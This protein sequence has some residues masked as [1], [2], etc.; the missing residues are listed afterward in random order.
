M[1]FIILFQVHTST[2][3]SAQGWISSTMI[4]LKHIPS[5]TLS[6]INED[7]ALCNNMKNSNQ[8]FYSKRFAN[9]KDDSYV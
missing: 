3:F 6:S 5:I 2:C 9:D 7:P 4:T 8:L 1:T